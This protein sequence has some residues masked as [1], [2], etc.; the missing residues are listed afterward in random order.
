MARW[1]ALV[2]VFLAAAA[3][4]QRPEPA[5]AVLLVAKPGLPDP[6]FS[7]TVVLVTRTPDLQTVGVILNR[8]LPLEL[9]QIVLD[10]SLTKNYRGPVFFGGPVMENTLVALFRSG[11]APEAPAFGMV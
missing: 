8:P 1:P 6:R 11:Q 5:S 2:L 9:S 10:K 3:A 4:A 7:Q